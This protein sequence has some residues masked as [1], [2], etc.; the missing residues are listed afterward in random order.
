MQYIEWI[1]GRDNPNVVLIDFNEDF[2]KEGD[3]SKLLTPL[4][5]TQIVS[6]PTQ[7]RGSLLYYIYLKN[8]LIN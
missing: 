8:D 2:L 5:F 6:G 1:I 3:L 7:M 4:D